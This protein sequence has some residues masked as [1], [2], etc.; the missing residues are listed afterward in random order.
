MII[1]TITC[2]ILLFICRD[3][4]SQS[5]DFRHFTP[6]DGLSSSEVY[7]VFQD[8]KGYIWFATDNGVSR[9]DGYEFRNFSQQDGLPD[10]TVFEIYED[11][12]NRIWFIPHSAKF[13]YFKNDSIIEYNYNDELSKK[14][15]QYSNPN[16]LSF[17]VDSL[18][19]LYYG[20]LYNGAFVVDRFGETKKIKNRDGTNNLIIKDNKLIL[21]SRLNRKRLDENLNHIYLV[22]EDS[23]F[24]TLP[25]FSTRV[26]LARAH[27]LTLYT[28]IKFE[29][30][31]RRKSHE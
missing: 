31:F 6:E 13:S 8:S 10:N 23:I 14:F 11:Y 5:F 22:L 28:W 25:Y 16:K 29:K 15:I 2:F 4:Y 7:H 20:D 19:N 17:Y 27:Y 30:Y 9:Y 12:Q 18:D 1:K 3:L 21:N 26:R 24:Y